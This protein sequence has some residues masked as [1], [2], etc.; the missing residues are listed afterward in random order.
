MKALTQITMMVYHDGIDDEEILSTA[1][2]FAD[3]IMLAL[4]DEHEIEVTIPEKNVSVTTAPFKV[5]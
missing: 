4:W 3:S 1:K 2:H 5:E